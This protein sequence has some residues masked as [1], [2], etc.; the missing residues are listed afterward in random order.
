[1]PEQP[2]APSDQELANETGPGLTTGRSALKRVVL[3]LLPFLFLLYLLNILDR[4]NVGIASLQMKPDL[5]LS[6]RAYALGAAIFYIGYISFEVPSNLILH[7]IGARR[8]ISRIMVSWGIV[9]AATMFVSQPWHFYTMRFLLGVAEAGFFPGIILYLS[10]WFTARERAMAVALFMTASPVSGLLGTP[11]SGAIMQYM[12]GVVGMRGWQWL[13]L[14]EGIP[15]IVLGF[16][17]WFYLTDRPEKARWLAEEQRAWLAARIDREEKRREEHHGLSRLSA[18]AD[19]RVCILI[20]LYFT[21]AVGSNCFGF[22]GPQIVQS[23]FTGQKEFV[24]GLLT[25]I[26]SLAAGMGMVAIG[27]HSDRSGERRWHVAGSAFLAGVGWGITA[28][29]AVLHS[30]W[31]AILGLVLAQTGM[32]GMLPTFW[33]LATSFLT[34]TAAAAGIALINSVGNLGG[35]LGP[36][37]MGELKQATDSFAAGLVVM[38]VTLFAGSALAL[39]VPHNPTLE[40]Q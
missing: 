1:M 38:S 35:F 5:Q 11:L 22:F 28:T 19:R 18:L 2:T 9:S 29:A 37:G 16:I 14:I 40:R 23:Q 27:L 15:S 7:R 13:F 17:A 24:I 32:M 6:D 34:G 31:V 12:H 8:W 30:P 21:V 33:A 26:P 39:C 36:L 3:R 10:F 25:A 20:A 4:G